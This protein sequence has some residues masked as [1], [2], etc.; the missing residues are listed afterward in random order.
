MRWAFTQFSEVA[1]IRRQSPAKVLL[2]QPVYQHACGERMIRPGDPVG[3]RRP[4]AGRLQHSRRRRDLRRCLAQYTGETGL[5]RDT[6]LRNERRRGYRPGIAR[7]K[8]HLRERSWLERIELLQLI[9]QP[10]PLRLG[11]ARQPFLQLGRFHAKL[12]LGKL[13]DLSLIRGAFLRPL[14]D[15]HLDFIDKLVEPLAGGLLQQRRLFDGVKA[16]ANRL[17]CLGPRNLFFMEYRPLLQRA[18]RHGCALKQ[19]CKE[20]LKAVVV[21]L[22]D[23]VEFMVMTTRTLQAKPE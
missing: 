17:G 16:F 20:S 18:N 21:T 2:P 23:R 9:A 12:S 4:A 10:L 22:R 14:A 3:Q 8:L 13:R 5:D 1:R 19:R 7:H 15:H 6:G 11:L